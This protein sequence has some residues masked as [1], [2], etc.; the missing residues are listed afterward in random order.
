MKNTP[1]GVLPPPGEKPA[2]KPAPRKTNRST[3][4][5]GSKPQNKSEKTEKSNKPA[6]TKVAAAPVNAAQ[7]KEAAPKAAG[8]TAAVPK[9][10]PCP[11][12]R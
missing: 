5:K 11:P 10:A 1:E 4:A 8:A 9:R 6:G 12:C 2:G 3:G 7:S